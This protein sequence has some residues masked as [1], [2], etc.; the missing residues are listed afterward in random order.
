MVLA[1]RGGAVVI[2]EPECSAT[3]LFDTVSGIL[4]EAGRIESMSSKMSELAKP[5][6]T[7]RIAETILELAQST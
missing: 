7:D 4:T 6:A 2:K 1:K 3:L 5:D